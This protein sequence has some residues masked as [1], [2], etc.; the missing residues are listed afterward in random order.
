MAFYETVSLLQTLE[1]MLDTSLMRTLLVYA[2]STAADVSNLV[3]ALSEA[4]GPETDAELHN[5]PKVYI[6]WLNFQPLRVLL[7][8]RSVAGGHGLERLTDGAPPGVAG[9]LHV[10]STMLSNIDRAPLRLKESRGTASTPTHAPVPLPLRSPSVPICTTD[11]CQA[12]VL[13][14]CFARAGTLA[15]TICA[16]YQNRWSRSFTSSSSLSSCSATRA[17]SSRRWR[18]V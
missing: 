15:A 4:L 14:N 6:R 13:D 10:V 9:L 16:S 5:V 12:L 8:C 1:L 7:S 3:S 17:A 11:L 2:E 18:Q